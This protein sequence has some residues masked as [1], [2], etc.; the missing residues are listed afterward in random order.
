MIKKAFALLALVASASI[1]GCG[2]ASAS[3][4]HGG[5]SDPMVY[6]PI[7]FVE[8]LLGEWGRD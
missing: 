4:A 1:L 2:V 8:E 5:D 3:P 7:Q 6:V